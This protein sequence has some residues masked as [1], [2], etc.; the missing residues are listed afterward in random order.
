MSK[1]L[2]DKY[3][4]LSLE[5][6]KYMLRHPEV[7][8]AIPNK[9][10]LVVTRSGDEELNC[11]SIGLIRKSRSRRPVVEARKTGRSWEVR[12]LELKAAG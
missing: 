5:F 8:D 2:A 4:E 6:D 1:E 7:L 10:M 11:H 9:A 3:I 12:P